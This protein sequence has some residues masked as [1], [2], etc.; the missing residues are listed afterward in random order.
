MEALVLEM[1]DSKTGVKS[2]TQRLV[3]TT[4][5]HA[6]T[7]KTQ[8]F[9]CLFAVCVCRLQCDRESCEIHI[10]AIQHLRHY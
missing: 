2:Q 7:G 9:K 8:Y 1:Q 6:I 10:S 3:I 4:I 5:P